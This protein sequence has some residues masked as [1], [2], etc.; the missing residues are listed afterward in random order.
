ML[1]S[2]APTTLSAS[3][4]PQGSGRL[5]SPCFV[6][7]RLGYCNS[8]FSGLPSY[9]T[10]CLQAVL[11]SSARMAA[12]TERYEH[13]TPVLRELHWLPYPHRITFRICLTTY[14]CLHDLAPDYFK[15]VCIPV[16]TIPG[17]DRNAQSR[18]ASLGLLQVPNTKT[19][20][21]RFWSFRPCGPRQ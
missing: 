12:H 20:N 3:L 14:R 7:C 2:V 19:K 10:A 17:T 8:A 11:N 13:I 21:F 9:L 16:S 4:P 1:L 18:F 5:I 6:T 15:S